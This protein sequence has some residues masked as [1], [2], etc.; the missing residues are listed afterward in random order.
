[1]GIILLF[2]TKSLLLNKNRVRCESVKGI[3]NT[4]NILSI[5]IDIGIVSIVPAKSNNNNSKN[6][7]C[8]IK[9]IAKT[10]VERDTFTFAMLVNARYH[11]EQGVSI[12]IMTPIHRDG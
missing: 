8:K 2:K 11:S 10:D 7:N 9:L 6:T 5:S 1:M 3:N 12:R 4:I